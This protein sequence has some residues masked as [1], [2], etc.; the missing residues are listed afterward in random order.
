M[1]VLVRK[2]WPQSASVLSILMSGGLIRKSEGLW[3]EGEGMHHGFGPEELFDGIDDH[4][5]DDTD[6]PGLKP[7]HTP[8]GYNP[9]TGKLKFNEDG[10]PAGYHAI[11]AVANHLR[12]QIEAAGLDTQAISPRALIQSAIDMH[13]LEHQMPDGS[14]GPHTL[15]GFDSVL[16]RRIFGG[17]YQKGLSAKEMQSRGLDPDDTGIA[18]KPL[19]TMN[20]NMGNVNRRGAATGRWFDSGY[21]PFYQALR[22]V[23]N[24]LNE[25]L[26]RRGMPQIDTSSMEYL[27]KPHVNPSK[28]SN[29]KV[30]HLRGGEG[31]H[32]LDTGRTYGEAL[33]DP[34]ANVSS[35][36][37]AASTLTDR[38]GFPEAF[39]S[40]P[41]NPDGTVKTTG[42]RGRKGK[43]DEETGEQTGG[44]RGHAVAA[45]RDAGLELTPDELDHFLAMPLAKVLFGQPGEGV[46]KR[47]LE[48]L[49]AEHGIDMQ[50][51]EFIRHLSSMSP[52]KLPKELHQTKGSHHYAH[53][54][55]ALSRLVG[56]K[57]DQSDYMPSD[58][59]ES[60][61]EDHE[62][63]AKILSH[64]VG[65]YEI[66]PHDFGAELQPS[67]GHPMDGSHH[68]FPEHYQD[69]VALDNSQMHPNTHLH[70][71]SYSREELPEQEPQAQ[72]LQM[73]S[74][75]MA[76]P[77]REATPREIAIRRRQ[78]EL[79]NV[80]AEQGGMLGRQFRG[81]TVTP[82]LAQQIQE[83]G[84]PFH[85]EYPEGRDGP[86]VTV[87]S[88]QTFFSPEG[89]WL[90]SRDDVLGAMDTVLKAMEDLQLETAMGDATVMKHVPTRLDT[91][92]TTEVGM[93]AKSLGLTG[94]D[95]RAIHSAQGDWSK[96]AK[97]WSVNEK[98]VRVIKAAM[99]GS[100]S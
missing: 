36:S 57:F 39:I 83:R 59:H 71:D 10:T 15:P 32:L 63:A 69:Y 47:I 26:G 29:N 4:P 42:R 92:S 3:H 82:Q 76:E 11:D 50:S 40:A 60:N 31:R 73:Q 100:L 43:V 64:M 20:L 75:P 51:P 27:T 88:H 78:A 52:Q 41:R 44:M 84:R 33:D 5:Y 96:V 55:A 34:N 54:L 58:L 97:Q 80:P 79:A 25:R 37:I 24:N 38:G 99:R 35:W 1:P 6:A 66:E 46:T 95:V 91:G 77:P 16:W 90:R 13:N 98:T 67:A 7:H 68:A 28:M 22:T 12:E 74:A 17:P 45:F 9:K 81:Q 23:V 85:Y 14:P 89:Q 72:P 30:R 65:H 56:D 61:I 8:Y 21:V 62:L 18:P 48:N 86:Q 2:S 87:A 19:Q 53:K 94:H 49:A 93:F 70:G